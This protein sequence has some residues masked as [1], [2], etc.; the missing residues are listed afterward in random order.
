MTVNSANRLSA[1]ALLTALLVA[2]TAIAATPP[3]GVPLAVRRGFFTDT[4]IGGFF[5]VGGDNGYSNLQSYLQLG[6]GYQLTIAG[7]AGLVPFGLQFG[8][9]ANGQ[10]CWA[11]L[12][13][14]GTCASADSFTV[15]FLTASVGY[16]FRVI[17]QLYLGPKVLAGGALLDPE[18]VA[19]VRSAAIVG[20][21]LSLEYATNMDHFSVGL[22]VS[23]RLVLGPKISAIASYPRV[24]YTF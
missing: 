5:T 9:G 24:Q 4:D 16:L 2:S 22:E 19:K 3:E 17:D 13:A 10:N 14:D 15:S 1:G 7:G 6:V 12:L 8:V 18:P 21:A 20:G 11:G 23:Y